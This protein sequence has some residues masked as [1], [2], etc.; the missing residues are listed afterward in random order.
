M[1][2]GLEPHIIALFQAMDGFAPVLISSE[3]A[4]DINILNLIKTLAANGYSLY[5]HVD[6]FVAVTSGSL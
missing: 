2:E 1:L 4:A 6:N 5:Q 3:F